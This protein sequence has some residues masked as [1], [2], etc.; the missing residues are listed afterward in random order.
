M[1]HSLDY[2]VHYTT[3]WTVQFRTIHVGLYSTVKYRTVQCSAVQYSAVTAMYLPYAHNL[4]PGRRHLPIYTSRWQGGCNCTQQDHCT[5]LNNCTQQE[6]CT[7][8]N[9]CTKQGTLHNTETLHNTDILHSTYWN[10]AQNRPVPVYTAQNMLK[11][12]ATPLSTLHIK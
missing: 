1:Q 12:C 3:L 6:H 5:T 10:T 4:S 8:L 2:T 7:T 11:H 9:N